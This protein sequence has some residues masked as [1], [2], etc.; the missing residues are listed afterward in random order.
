LKTVYFPE[1]LQDLP[2]PIQPDKPQLQT[3]R[4]VE[5]HSPAAHPV[6]VVERFIPLEIHLP[7]SPLHYALSKTAIQHQVTV[8]VL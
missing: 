1:G 2:L 3:S 7:H 8:D 5:I 4:T 6:Q